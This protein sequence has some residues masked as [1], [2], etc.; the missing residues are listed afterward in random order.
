MAQHDYGIANQS[1]SAF[2][3]DLNNALLAIAT[4]NSG[5]SEPATPYPY[6]LWVDTSATPAAIKQRNA[7]NAGW[8]TIGAADGSIYVP[9]GAR[10]GVGTTTPTAPVT[11]NGNVR[12]LAGGSVQ[13]AN[14]ANLQFLNAAGTS[15]SAGFRSVS[16]D[17]F[18]YTLDTERLRVSATGS[19]QFPNNTN[20][21]FLNAAGTSYSTGI[22]G[23]ADAL[24]F[25]TTDADRVSIGSDGIAYFRSNNTST[26]VAATSAA[27]GSAPY[28]FIGR[29]SS[30]SLTTGT[31]SF[32][33]SSGG[34]IYAV[35]TTVQSIASERRLKENIE[36]VDPETAWETIKSVPYYS[37]NFKGV[38]SS[39]VNYGPMVDEVPEEM[40]I[41]TDQSDEDGIIRTYNNSMLQARLYA[42]LQAALV[43]IETL[44]AKIAELEAV[45]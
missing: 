17:V 9:S 23:A 28:T 45:A 11:V 22:K 29:H 37:Y 32:R 14:A 39:Q 34:T 2:R 19:I 31:D 42:A 33:V 43:R 25:Y 3:A 18:L 16:D 15:Y 1:G 8:L 27:S 40:V 7:A 44:E 36:L 20:L 21:Q 41:E 5:S 24:T 13:L 4:T 35:N 30:G 12:L 38:D 6:Q 26:I 10:L